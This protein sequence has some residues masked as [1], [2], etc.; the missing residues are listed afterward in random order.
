MIKTKYEKQ[1]EIEREAER[2]TDRGESR[3]PSLSLISHRY[4]NRVCLL[5]AA[6]RMKLQPPLPIKGKK[7]VSIHFNRD[8]TNRQSQADRQT[9][10]GKQRQ[11]T[12]K[13]RQADI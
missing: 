9:E 5:A 3:R 4:V 11:Q 1:R 6:E 10:T 12:E 13:D 8:A 2:P 7:L